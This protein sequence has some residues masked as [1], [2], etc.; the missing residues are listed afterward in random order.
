VYK[1][2]L[3]RFEHVFFDGGYKSP[4][5]K[6]ANVRDTWWYLLQYQV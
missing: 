2:L 6:A 3:I 5:D 1:S 4:K